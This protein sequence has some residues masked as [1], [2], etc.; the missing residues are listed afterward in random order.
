MHK[1]SVSVDTT[2]GTKKDVIITC[3]DQTVTVDIPDAVLLGVDGT[4]P[5]PSKML[6]EVM[7]LVGRGLTE[8]QVKSAYVAPKPTKPSPEPDWA[9]DVTGKPITEKAK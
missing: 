3:G 4:K 1:I 2:P 7:T 8:L 6:V 5:E 9:V